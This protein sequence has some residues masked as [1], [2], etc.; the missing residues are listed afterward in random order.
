[1]YLTLIILRK[2]NVYEIFSMS[3]YDSQTQ[4]NNNNYNQNS[5]FANVFHITAQQPTNIENLMKE[6]Y[7]SDS[8]PKQQQ[9]T[10][11]MTSYESGSGYAPSSSSHKRIFTAD[12]MKDRTLPALVITDLLIYCSIV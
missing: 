1:M 10:N 9:S 11:S 7:S 12:V 4:Y 8:G 3:N 2:I 5:E 6:V